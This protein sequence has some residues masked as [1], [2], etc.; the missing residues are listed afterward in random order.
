MILEGRG[1]PTVTVVTQPF[2]SLARQKRGSLG[3]PELRLVGVPYP[4]CGIPEPDVCRLAD[5][6]FQQVLQGIIGEVTE[7]Y[8][9]SPHGESP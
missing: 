4:V 9:D 6:A 5:G 3:L 7:S 8:Q 2:I 1:I